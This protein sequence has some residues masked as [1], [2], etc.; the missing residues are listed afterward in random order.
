MYHMTSYVNT[1]IYV[2]LNLEVEKQSNK[3]T[4]KKK[5]KNANKQ[6]L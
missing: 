4:T 5:E 1:I 3:Q 6:S 2:V